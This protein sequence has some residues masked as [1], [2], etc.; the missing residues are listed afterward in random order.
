MCDICQI[1]GEK[2]EKYLDELVEQH[3]G[4][5]VDGQPVSKAHHMETALA[6]A[7]T[8]RTPRELRKYVAT[9]LAKAEMADQLMDRL[10]M[11]AQAASDSK[12]AMVV[13][14]KEIAA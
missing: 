4:T 13:V 9:T 10:H 2:L 14:Q 11:T 5:A 6:V 12:P 1:V 3:P 7:A 8:R